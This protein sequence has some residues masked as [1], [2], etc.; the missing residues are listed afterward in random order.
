MDM[1][2]APD[3]IDGFPVIVASGPITEDSLVVLGA[4]VRK[5][6]DEGGVQGA[7]IDCKDIEGALSPE[8]IYRATPAFSITIGQDIKVAYINPPASWSPADDQFSRDL[9]YNRGVML[10]V[11]DTAD[12]AAHWLRQA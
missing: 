9:A 2:L 5:T 10:E 4:F 12:D 7:I 1:S 8:S 6:C 3:A 11:F